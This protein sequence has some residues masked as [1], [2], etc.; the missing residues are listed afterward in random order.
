[1]WR[2]KDGRLTTACNFSC[3]RSDAL[4]RSL[5]ATKV[6][7]YAG[8]LWLRRM[9]VVNLK[10][11][12]LGVGRLSCHSSWQPAFKAAPILRR[13]HTSNS[14]TSWAKDSQTTTLSFGKLPLSTSDS[15]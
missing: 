11:L 4:F 9:E 1:L 12:I 13:P 6:P 15:H 7:N 2:I 14:A 5:W 3:R 10:R 8:R